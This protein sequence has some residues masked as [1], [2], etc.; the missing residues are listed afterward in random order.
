MKLLLITE[1]FP[2]T[3]HVDVHGGMEVRSY[4]T[5]VRLADAHE[6]T[7]I[8]SLDGD[9]PKTQYINKIRVIRVGPKRTYTSNSQILVRLMYMWHAVLYGLRMPF[10]VVEAGGL[11]SWLPA[12]IIGS[13]KKKKR[14]MV[15]ADLVE[16]YAGRVSLLSKSLLTL[17]Q[18][19]LFS[20]SWDS[21][22]S[23]SYTTAK[24][25]QSR[26][27]RKNNIEVIYCGTKIEQISNLKVNKIPFKI[28]CVSRLVSYKRIEDL[29]SAIYYVHDVFPN[30][31]LDIVGIGEDESKL[32]S[33]AARLGLINIK[34]HGFV[35]NQQ[36]VWKLMKESQLFCLPSIVEGFGLVTI[37]AMAGGVPV[38]LADVPIHHEITQN[39]GV[40]FFT[41]KNSKHLSRVLIQLFQNRTLYQ[42]LSKE[43][44]IQAARYNWSLVAKK[45]EQLYENLCAD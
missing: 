30:I 10:D 23:I 44:Q 34:F 24:K 8:A 6:V 4:E 31:V 28:C 21:V 45:T 40:V 36:K 26:N 43:A 2:S 11:M 27:V 38:V 35:K 14:V 37:E 20:L 5:A 22:I 25:L 9:K 18:N 13:V 15:V 7:V 19:I 17:Y 1:Y 12:W 29:I 16:E 33:L 39:R 32:K 42:R 3:T 41:P